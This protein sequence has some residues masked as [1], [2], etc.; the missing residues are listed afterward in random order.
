[1][2]AEKALEMQAKMCHI[3]KCVNCGLK[4]TN[5]E[6]SFKCLEY[7]ENHPKKALKIVEKWAIE[8]GYIKDVEEPLHKIAE[9]YGLKAQLNQLQEECAELITAISHYMRGRD[10]EHKE[11]DEEMADVKIILKQIEYLLDNKKEVKEVYK[12]KMQRELER[13]K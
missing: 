1:M 5:N 11:I 7:R 8:N 13:I 2:K 6:L 4:N 10:N 9:H 3:G 12:S